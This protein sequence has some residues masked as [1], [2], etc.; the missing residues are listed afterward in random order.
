MGIAATVAGVATAVGVGS[1][2]AAGIGAVVSAGVI[3]GA[4][5]LAGDVVGSAFS[6]GGSGGQAAAA[7][8]SNSVGISQNS[9]YYGMSGYSTS[10]VKLSNTPS[11][12]ADMSGTP[13]KEQPMMTPDK[14]VK[15]PVATAREAPTQG[16]TEMAGD[17]KQDFNGVW[18]D[19]LS[20]YLDY[21]TRSLG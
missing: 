1:A 21:N 20:H 5:T 9:P 15:A 16:A 2:T 17:A 3:A 10:G 11:H 12:G 14:A 13:P 7:N 18:A 6:G 19:R 4:T 8:N